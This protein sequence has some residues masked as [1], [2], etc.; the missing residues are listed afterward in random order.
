MTNIGKVP[1]RRLSARYGI[2]LLLAVMLAG[3]N[4]CHRD[5]QP[6]AVDTSQPSIDTARQPASDTAN[7][8]PDK[9]S[10][11]HSA[12]DNELQ[13]K[14]D[15]AE[16]TNLR[17]FTRKQKEIYDASLLIGEWTRGTEHEVYLADG[18]GRMWDMSED[19]SRDEAQRFN[20]T[21]DSNL[22]TIVCHLELGG[23]LPKRYVVTYA[24]DESLAYQDVHGNPYLL[25]KQR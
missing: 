12:P 4:G 20:W 16:I 3:C 15:S 1:V 10:V 5:G 14:R 17:L 18:T 23:V 22:L 6:A 19:V 24:D 13:L 2:M 21:L 9:D 25:D 7:V 11:A 8:T